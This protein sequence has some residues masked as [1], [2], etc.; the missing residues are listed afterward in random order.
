[1]YWRKETFSKSVSLC[2]YVFSVTSLIR[3]LFG[4]SIDILKLHMEIHWL[5][6]FSHIIFWALSKQNYT[7]EIYISVYIGIYCRDYQKPPF[8]NFSVNQISELDT[9]T[10]TDSKDLF[11]HLTAYVTFEY[12]FVIEWKLWTINVIG[13]WLLLWIKAIKTWYSMLELPGLFPRDVWGVT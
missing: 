13:L 9:K 5:S 1:M 10:L 7:K 8:C 11:I 4:D 2:W 6:D 3:I 12:E